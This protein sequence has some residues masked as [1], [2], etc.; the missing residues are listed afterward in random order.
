MRFIQAIT[1]SKIIRL[2]TENLNTAGAVGEYQKALVMCIVM[3][4]LLIYTERLLV[5]PMPL[6]MIVST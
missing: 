2:K 1:G 3:K 5:L 6:S 4:I